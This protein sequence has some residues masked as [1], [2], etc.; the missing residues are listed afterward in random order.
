LRSGG[1]LRMCGTNHGNGNKNQK[2]YPA[3]E[4]ACLFSHAILQTPRYFDAKIL[5][6]VCLAGPPQPVLPRKR[7]HHSPV[8]AK[9]AC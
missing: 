8:G 6:C 2:H 1:G 5:P 4:N 3:P 9:R 7:G